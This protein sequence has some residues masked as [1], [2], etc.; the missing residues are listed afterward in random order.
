MDGIIFLT[1]LFP[2]ASVAQVD[3]LKRLERRRGT[4]GT[5]WAHERTSAPG[6]TR[7]H[8][9]AAKGEGRRAGFAAGSTR[10]CLSASLDGRQ[11]RGRPVSTCYPQC[12]RLDRRLDAARVF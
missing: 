4:P 2:S 3:C 7:V 9:Y 1:S 11:V 12:I 10:Q 6:P 8:V 5:G